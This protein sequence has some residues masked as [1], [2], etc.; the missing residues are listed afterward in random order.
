M[1]APSNETTNGSLTRE[2]LYAIRHYLGGWRGMLILAATAIVAGLVL[3]WSWLVATGIAPI[4]LIALPC[5]IM[6]GLGLCM[7]HLRGESCE[8]NSP[9]QR[10]AESRSDASATKLRRTSIN[11]RASGCCHESPEA[12]AL[13]GAEQ[14][15][16]PEERRDPHA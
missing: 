16:A 6:C 4:L 8:S 15:Q 13:T 14:N 12:R 2:W 9:R 3:N 1:N 10:D 5:L 11:D 7:N